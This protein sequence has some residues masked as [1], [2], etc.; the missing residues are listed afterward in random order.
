MKKLTKILKGYKHICFF[1]LEGTQ[2]SH[3]CIAIGAVLALINKKGQIKKEK[4]PFKI[5]VKSKNKVGKYVE[6]LTG[7]K[8]EML[9]KEGVSFKD[10][11]HQFKTYLGAAFKNSL[12]MSFG[13]HD[14]TIVKNSIS[15][16]LDAPI[17][18][19]RQ[20][21][22]NYCDFIPIIS[23]FIKDDNNSP[24]SL[25]HYCELF[26]C[27]SEGTPHNP[28]VDAINLKNLYSAFLSNK[29]IVIEGY[30]KVLYKMNNLPL[31]ILRM[32]QKLKNGED[33]SPKSFE[34]EVI[35]VINDD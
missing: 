21:Q 30:K 31:P 13:N 24:M 11:M 1:D 6:N 20:I 5:Y 26:N 12:F 19:C 8:D 25:V 4:S 7:I 16:N 10:A 29:D 17:E 32:M 22:K 18:I 3:E 33:V 27:L 34:D 2:I 9:D 23:E 14:M 28:D 35:K 15:Y